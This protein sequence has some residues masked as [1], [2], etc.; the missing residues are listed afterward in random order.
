MAIKKAV[1]KEVQALSQEQVDAAIKEKAL[2][3][4]AGKYSPEQYDNFMAAL[5]AK[6]LDGNKARIESFMKHR[7]YQKL[8]LAVM[9][10]IVTQLDA[11]AYAES[12]ELYNSTLGG[13]DEL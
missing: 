3:L 9:N 13:G 12:C 5:N 4:G 10:A 11:W 6:C 2:E 7:D 1:K 8:G